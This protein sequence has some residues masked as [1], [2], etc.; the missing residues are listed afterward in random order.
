[1]VCVRPHGHR[2]LRVRSGE[3]VQTAEVDD[4]ITAAGDEVDRRRDGWQP[5]DGVGGEQDATEGAV[6]GGPRVPDTVACDGCREV[7][8]Q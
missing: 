4:T 3:L 5:V 6:V 8:P 1:V 7:G 2:Q